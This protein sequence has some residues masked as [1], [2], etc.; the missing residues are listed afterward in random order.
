VKVHIAGIRHES[1]TDGPGLRS[2]LFFQG[3]LHACPGCHNPQTWD[4]HGGEEFEVEDLIQ[5]FQITPLLSGFTLSGGEPFLQPQAA[6]RI[7]EYVKSKGMNLW[8]YTGYSWEELLCHL[9]EPGYRDLIRWADVIVDGPYRKEL[10]DLSLPY[11]GSSNQ[12]FLLPQAS[13][14]Q[15]Q[16]VLWQNT[17]H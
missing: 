14:D 1:V 2:V 13:L 3:C 11:R 8:V 12:R 15:T 4:V 7:A 5:N 10:R 17:F 9:D 6:A 16:V